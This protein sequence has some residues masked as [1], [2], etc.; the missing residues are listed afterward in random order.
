[1]QNVVDAKKIFKIVTIG[2]AVVIGVVAILIFSGKF[3]GIENSSKKNTNKPTLE[4]WGSIPDKIFRDTLTEYGTLGYKP[5]AINYVYFDR[6]ILNQKLIELGAGGEGPDMIIGEY[7]RLLTISGMMYTLPYN[8]MTELDFK[9]MYV[10]ATH[11]LATPYGASMYPLLVDPTI[12]IFNKKILSENGF[13]YPPKYWSELPAYQ[14]KLTN[15]NTDSKPAQSAFGI[16]ANNVTNQKHIL[17]TQLLQLGS[18]PAKYTNGSIFTDVGMG[19]TTFEDTT[20]NLV[21]MLRFQSAFSD[22]QKTSFTWSETDISDKDKFTSGDS[23]IY[24]GK[25]SDINYILSKN[26][27]LEIGLYFMPQLEDNR[28]ETVSGE[29]TGIAVGKFTKDLAYTVETAQ[30]LANVDFSRVL[31]FKTGQAGARRDVLYGTDGSERSEVVGRS[32]L[33]TKL[34]YDNNYEQ[35]D[36]LIFNLYENILSGR[37]TIDGAAEDFSANWTNLF[38]PR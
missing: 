37:K 2:L 8:Y 30:T 29:M 32:A 25:A 18:N 10:D 35:V 16:G 38:S 23:V 4:I 7:N 31:S 20:P 26:P 9:N 22:P 19:A 15:L 1:M 34:I 11:I 33:V 17:Y 24:F 12:M 6:D 5:L 28:Y 21:K 3:P 14:Q 27:S 13:V 36:T